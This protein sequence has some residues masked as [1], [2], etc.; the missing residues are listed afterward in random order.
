MQPRVDGLAVDDH[1][2]LTV[3]RVGEFWVQ[4]LDQHGALVLVAR[5]QQLKVESLV[6]PVRTGKRPRPPVAGLRL[7]EPAI[8]RRL[9]LPGGVAISR[10][11]GQV[12]SARALAGPPGLLVAATAG[13]AATASRTH[14]AIVPALADRVMRQTTA[15]HRC[16]LLTVVT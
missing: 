4:C 11:C 14:R 1:V 7:V 10:H 5:F 6:G 12:R 2:F 8:R 3:Q 16:A 13:R 15:Q 9:L